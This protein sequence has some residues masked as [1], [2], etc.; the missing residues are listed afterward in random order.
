M[1]LLELLVIFMITICEGH[2]LYSQYLSRLGESIAHIS[3]PCYQIGKPAR[4]LAARYLFPLIVQIGSLGEL[5]EL[6]WAVSLAV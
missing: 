1:L 2:K 4:L 3:S 6:S 5:S